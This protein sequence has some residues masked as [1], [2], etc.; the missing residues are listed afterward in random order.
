M[1]T[2]VVND[3]QTARIDEANPTKRRERHDGLTQK[4]NEISP[5]LVVLDPA[6]AHVGG[7]DR[8]ICWHRV[9]HLKVPKVKDLPARKDEKLTVLTEVVQRYL[10]GEAIPG[11]SGAMMYAVGA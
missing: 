4:V 2:P 10:R 8:S 3:Q 7:I 11:D 9:S 1:L 5:V 6:K